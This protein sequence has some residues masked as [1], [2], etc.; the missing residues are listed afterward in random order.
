M[1][2]PDSC[3]RQTL[4]LRESMDEQ[5]ETIALGSIPASDRI[6]LS[7]PGR[8][9]RCT[10]IHIAL[11]MCFEAARLEV[12]LLAHRSP[13]AVM[14]C[15]AHYQDQTVLCDLLLHYWPAIGEK[16]PPGH[17]V[18]LRQPRCLKR[19][20]AHP[21]ASPSATAAPATCHICHR[22]APPASAHTRL[23][24]LSC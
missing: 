6:V 20:R 21:C 9:R 12:D 2:H 18:H 3:V 24:S 5:G 11:L 19:C 22:V 17:W 7:V 1:S 15:D 8:C 23:W 16:D 14:R 10:L 13:S 4:I